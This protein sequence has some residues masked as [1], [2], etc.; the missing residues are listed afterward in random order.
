MSEKDKNLTSQAKRC[1]DWYDAVSLEKQAE[2]SEAK[3]FIHA[4]MIRLYRAEEYAAGL[5]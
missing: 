5:L 3:E 2:S 1:T 4:R